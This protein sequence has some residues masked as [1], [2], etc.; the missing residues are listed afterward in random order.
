MVLIFLAK[1]PLTAK[2]FCLPFL[3]L[4]LCYENDINGTCQICS[5][6]FFYFKHACDSRHVTFFNAIQPSFRIQT[7][8]LCFLLSLFVNI[9]KLSR[10]PIEVS[11]AW[12]LNRYLVTVLFSATRTVGTIRLSR[13]CFSLFPHEFASK[14]RARNLDICF[15]CIIQYVFECA[16]DGLHWRR[17][18]R[19]RVDAYLWCSL[20]FIYEAGRTYRSREVGFSGIKRP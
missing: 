15:F 7:L 14:V 12:Q 18:A 5:L 1:S 3:Y 19:A 13:M 11:G 16:L 20:L 2:V 10:L 9:Y 17:R 4:L 8:R 6:P